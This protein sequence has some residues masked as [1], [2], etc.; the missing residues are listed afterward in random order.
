MVMQ[1]QRRLGSTGVDKMMCDGLFRWLLGLCSPWV[2]NHENAYIFL[3]QMSFWFIVT[4][5]IKLNEPLMLLTWTLKYCLSYGVLSQISEARKD[6]WS[7]QIHAPHPFEPLLWHLQQVAHI[8]CLNMTC[9]Q[10]ITSS[11]L[12]LNVSSCE[13]ILPCSS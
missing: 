12:S 5:T 4:Y 6:L 2:W 10:E 9:N 8:F 7:D 13:K 1:T 11:H 3:L